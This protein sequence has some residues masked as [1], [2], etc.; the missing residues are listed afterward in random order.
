MEIY[1]RIY[2]ENK[3]FILVYIYKL[4]IYIYIYISE[5]ISYIAT[6]ESCLKN[7]SKVNFS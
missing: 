7:D 2:I 3:K 1:Y 6:K 5:T 4:H